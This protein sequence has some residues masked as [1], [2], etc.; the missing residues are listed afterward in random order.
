MNTVE[1]VSHTL[2]VYSRSAANATARIVVGGR[3]TFLLG[4][5]H[6]VAVDAVL[7]A[8][9]R[10]VQAAVRAVDLAG[11][12]A[13]LEVGASNE[14]GLAA[15]KVAAADGAVGRV[16]AGRAH[17]LEAVADQHLVVGDVHLLAAERDVR[18][19]AAGHD[20]DGQLVALVVGAADVDRCAVRIVA[21]DDGVSGEAAVRGAGYP[22]V[23]FGGENGDGVILI[24]T[25]LHRLNA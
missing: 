23:T 8:A 21:G 18:V 13:A 4:D 22:V 12:Q 20:L 16:P 6:L 7:L 11:R 2:A 24:A 10:N 19:L 1:L 14:H 9:E 5:Q 25:F 15:G 3:R 17:P